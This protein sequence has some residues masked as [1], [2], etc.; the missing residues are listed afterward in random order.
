[1]KAKHAL[2]L[3][4][5]LTILIASNVYLFSNFEKTQR[6]KVTITRVIDG[7]TLELEDKSI[8]R[9]ENINTPEKSVKGFEE[10]KEFLA[11]YERKK[12]EIEITGYDKYGRLLGK[13]Y[14]PEY[15][16]YLQPQSEALADEGSSH[17][18][19]DSQA[20]R[21]L[22]LEIVSEGL[23]TK[24]LV[25]NEEKEL[26][27]IAEESAISQ[28]KG[29]WKKSNY[30]DCI[31]SEINARNELIILKSNCGEINIEN[32]I[33]GDESRKRYEFKSFN[34]DKLT[35]HTSSGKDNNTDIFWNLKT[36]VWNND[37][38]TLYLFD[39]GGELVHHESYGY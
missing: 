2:I 8:V 19:R 26:F 32:W 25:S 7:D 36:N 21:Y 20:S 27:S 5:V 33:L 37:R 39:S 3:S 23:A 30:F 1:M 17:S 29:I 28:E 10:A 9:L 12:V 6:K 35:F 34:L 15:A 13:I 31:T 14:T 24:F 4:I 38:D 22:N 11:K 18:R 16:N